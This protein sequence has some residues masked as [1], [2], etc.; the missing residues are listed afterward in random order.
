MVWPEFEECDI[1][2]WHGLASAFHWRLHFASET[3]ALLQG[4]QCLASSYE[5]RDQRLLFSG[6]M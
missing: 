5:L 2:P 1:L 4:L 3:R 6:N